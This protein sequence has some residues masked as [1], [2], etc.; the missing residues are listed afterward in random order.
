MEIDFILL[1]FN[2]FKILPNMFY[3]IGFIESLL[4]QDMR[5]ILFVTGGIIN[6]VINLVFS[7]ILGGKL[8][9]SNSENTY[10]NYCNSFFSN[11]SSSSPQFAD[12]YIQS[13]AYIV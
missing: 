9:P 3:I 8:F 2:F 12:W 10:D 11:S 7:K 1:F 13:L 4:F 6:S 5:G